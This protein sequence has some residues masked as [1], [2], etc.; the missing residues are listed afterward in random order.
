MS[1]YMTETMISK[2]RRTKSGAIVKC[3]DCGKFHVVLPSNNF[4]DSIHYVNCE[5]QRKTAA[6]MGV[7]TNT[8]LVRLIDIVLENN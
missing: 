3:N 6:I 2:V 5:G 4:E 1:N 7:L 8:S